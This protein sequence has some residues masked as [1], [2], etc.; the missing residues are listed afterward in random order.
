MWHDTMMSV[1]KIENGYVVEVRVPYVPSGD[2]PEECYPEAREKQFFVATPELAGKKIAE[3]LPVLA[4]KK[5]ADKA[6]KEFFKEAVD[7]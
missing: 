6:F 5:D 2:R 3:L 1:G 4:S 7:D